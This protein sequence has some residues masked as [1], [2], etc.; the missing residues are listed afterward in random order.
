MIG[1]DFDTSGLATILQEASILRIT[2]ATHFTAMPLC[3]PAG[4][5]ILLSEGDDP[6]CTDPQGRGRAAI[7]SLISEQ[8]ITDL[9]F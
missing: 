5:A 2:D 9:E 8:I 4:E 6:V 7:H 1:V 3:K